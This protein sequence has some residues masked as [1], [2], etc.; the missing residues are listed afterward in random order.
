MAIIRDKYGNVID[1]TEAERSRSVCGDWIYALF[2][3][4]ID[5]NQI[6]DNYGNK[7]AEI[8]GDYI[9]DTFGTRLVE[10]RGDRIYDMSGTMLFILD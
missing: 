10:I 7:V 9:C 1:R 8:R 5:G 6:Y 3:G 4:R 2:E